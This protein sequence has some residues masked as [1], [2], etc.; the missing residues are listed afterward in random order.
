MSDRPARPRSLLITLCPTGAGT[1]AGAHGLHP[2]ALHEATPRPHPGWR[3]LRRSALTLALLLSACGGGGGGGSSSTAAASGG[4]PTAAVA[5]P[6]GVGWASATALVDTASVPSGTTGVTALNLGAQRTPAPGLASAQVDAIANG[7]T[8]L[9]TSGWVNTVAL[10][11]TTLAADASCW[12]PAVAY[13]HHDD[14]ASSGTL[15]AGEV[16]LWTDHDASDPQGACAATQVSTRLASVSGQAQQALLLLAA[17]RWRVA[18]DTTLGMPNTGMSTDLTAV[19]GSLLQP[20]LNGISVSAASVSVSDDGSQQRFRI[21]LA[22]GSGASAQSLELALEHTPADTDTHYAGALQVAHSFLSSDSALGCT[23]QRDG[24]GR[25]KLARLLTLG[26][27]RQDEWL[28]LRARSGLYC[29]NGSAMSASQIGDLA[30]L[31]LSGELDPAVY[32]SGN[33]RSGISGWRR[34]FLR[35]SS[36][37][38]MSAQTSDFMLAWQ[39]QPQAGMGH[40]RLLAGHAT[41]NT[42]TAS[43]GLMLASGH[44]DDISITDGALLGLICNVRGPGAN[45]TVH[46]SFQWQQASLG[47]SASGWV[48]GSS[49]RRYAPNNAC[50]ATANM[51][52]DADGDSVLGA[53]EGMSALPDLA[54]PSQ[55]GLDAQDELNVRGFQSPILLL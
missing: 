20:V 16:G 7:R 17:L 12:S 47:A 53:T 25:Y 31:T 23:D 43:R 5:F 54:T 32:L 26:Y 13:A 38:L 4:S 49:Q 33:S 42:S 14:D 46:A 34:H 19:A 15:A 18:S 27:N 30:S 41:L 11:D 37:H 21:V 29:G 52:F 55:N 3:Q 45:A 48:L 2:P 10:F 50:A 35:W 6:F 44:T 39:D 24:A 36:D 1:A 22:Q 8:A 40:A 9:S 28:S 51:R